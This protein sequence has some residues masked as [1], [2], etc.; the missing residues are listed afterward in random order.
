MSELPPGFELDH[1]D[2]ALPTGFVL[3]N[4][5]SLAGVAKSLGTGLAEGGI[6]LAG[7][8][9]DLS[10]LLAKGSQGA[11]NYI[12]G[13]LGI[14]RGPQAGGPLLPTSASLQKNVEGVTGPFYQPQG[15][16]ENIA[17]K[18]GQFAPAAIGGP[19][20]LAAKIGTRVV[21]PAVASEAGGQIAGPYGEL[22]GALLGAG[23]ASAAAQKFKAMAAARQ[24]PNLAI[25]DI[26]AA[27]QAQY[28]HPDVS[29]LQ[30]KPQAVSDLGATIK[31][32][33]ESQGA[34]DYREKNT[35]SGV[36]ELSNP[37]PQP[38]VPFAGPMPKTVADI[39]AV[40]RGL[41]N[42][43][44]E[45]DAIG[46]PT[47][48]A[49]AATKAINH[50][51]DFLANIK[52]PDLLA[53]D[54]SKAVPILQDARAN[55]SAMKK[56]QEVQ[57]KLGNAE[58]SAASANSGGNIQNSI[59]QQFKPLLMNDAKK[60]IGYTDAEKEQINNIIRGTWTGKAARA[61]GNLLGGG[62]GLGMLAGGAA[63]YEAGG[64][65]G[66]IAAGLA[67][68]GL[69]KIGNSST[70]NAVKK[71]DT[72]IRARSPEAIKMAA[73]NPQIAQVLPA[74][75]TQLLRTMIL[76]DPTLRKQENQQVSQQPR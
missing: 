60:A 2:A 56:A 25:D 68:R 46:A 43:A 57:N 19:E 7:L 73:Q 76:A 47:S 58:L 66:A 48:D 55:W 67:G 45:R 63:G 42:T 13:K 27:A 21:A 32:D 12:A 11:S 14:D 4:G 51:D 17:S 50:I 65:P 38:T 44:L 22:G 5:S 10:N 59:K 23:G 53:G 8:P 62:G 9:G 16:A 29:A 71:L 49:R 1:T 75:T 37:A 61:A 70:F 18:I 74:K 35:F 30:I 6:G 64:V 41:G 33:L 54:A 34:R 26:K 20:T 3:D 28:Q 36:S 72:M 31:A 52:Q 24:V 40:R 15:T 69:K 39:E